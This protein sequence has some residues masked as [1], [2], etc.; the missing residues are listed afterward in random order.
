MELTKKQIQVISVIEHL[1]GIKLN[2][3]AINR[4]VIKVRIDDNRFFA[5]SD[6]YVEIARILH[7]YKLGRVEPNGVN[8]IA[9]IL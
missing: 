8:Y 3:S 5:L 9:I 4:K 1:L 7:K 2:A 6:L